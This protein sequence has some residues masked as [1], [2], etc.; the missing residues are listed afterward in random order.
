MIVFGGANDL[1]GIGD[2][3]QFDPAANSWTPMAV[4][5]N[6]QGV[7]RKAVWTGTEMVVWGLRGGGGRYN[8]ALDTWT[9]MSSVNAPSGFDGHSMVW[10]GSKVVVWGGRPNTNDFAVMN[11][12]GRYDPISDTWQP[13]STVGAPVAR[14]D[15]TAVWTG[16]RM[17]VWGGHNCQCVPSTTYADGGTYDP[18]ADTWAPMS[19]GGPFMALHKAV[20]TGS[21][22]IVWK[23]RVGSRYDP[24]ADTWSP[25]A[26]GPWGPC[27]TPHEIANLGDES[28]V[29]TGSR[30]IVWGGTSSFHGL[31]S[32]DGGG[33]YDPVTNTWQT[34]SLVNAAAPRAQHTAVWTGTHMIIWGGQGLASG[35]GARYDP[36]LDRWT[37]VATQNE[38]RGRYLHQAVWDG[39]GMMVYDGYLTNGIYYNKGG[40]YL[41]S[42]D[43]DHDGF[44]A[45]GGDCNDASA[46]IHPGVTE[47]C[48]GI[49]Q[50]C[51]QVVD[52]APDTDGDGVGACV[53]CAEG[54]AQVWAMPAE[55]A[56]FG[57]T[58]TSPATWSWDSLASQSGP[59]ISYDVVTGN[60]SA[61]GFD[62]GSAACLGST[63]ANAFSDARPDPAVNSGYWYLVGGRNACGSGTL[64]TPQRDTVGL[65]LC[66]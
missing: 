36:V 15:H 41:S 53:D 4:N 47:I 62:A 33:R 34:T 66:P 42:Q 29:W 51:N 21:L 10:T 32:T 52:D 37:P 20:W 12:G 27:C 40:R 59:Q 49:D 56:N 38:P 45:C 31:F 25:V 18:V 39:A 57:A 14:L 8:P 6:P 23:A 19:S 44:T 26:P 13:T 9:P 2:G 55:V 65:G 50:D 43:A 30:M 11:T 54:N 60:F 7:G 1:Y 3:A 22:M 24:V 16:Q 48:D 28:L 5:L 17:I 46:A 35:L 61:A 64:G 63:T 58:A